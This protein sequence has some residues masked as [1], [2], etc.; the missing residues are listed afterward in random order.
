[1]I[2][3]MVEL[4]LKDQGNEEFKKGGYLKAAALYT[5]A[6]KEDP[7]NHVLYRYPVSHIYAFGSIA[8][9][10]YARYLCQIPWLCALKQMAPRPV[11]LLPG[12]A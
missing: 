5:K 4:S 6:I 3:T 12:R 2:N 9:H 7:S 8:R 1:M 10:A 11:H